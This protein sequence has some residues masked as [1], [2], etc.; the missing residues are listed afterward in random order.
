MPALEMMCAIEMAG[1]TLDRAR[2]ATCR[3]LSRAQ[4]I[5]RVKPSGGQKQKTQLNITGS[6]S[7][8]IWA[9]LRYLPP[10]ALPPPTSEFT[11]RDQLKRSKR[12]KPAVHT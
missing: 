11:I 1:C 5:S 2:L 9:D 10:A 7:Y 4:Q 8:S 12:Q 6:A 3:R